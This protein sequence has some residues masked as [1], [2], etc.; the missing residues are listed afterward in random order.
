[1]STVRTTVVPHPA[2]GMCRLWLRQERKDATLR[3]ADQN[4]EPIDPH[5]LKRR[6]FTRG[7]CLD[8]P[9]NGFFPLLS[10]IRAWPS[11]AAS[12]QSCSVYLH[13]KPIRSCDRSSNDPASPHHPSAL[14]CHAT[15]PSLSLDCALQVGCPSHLERLDPTGG[16]GLRWFRVLGLE[17]DLFRRDLNLGGGVDGYGGRP[18]MRV[19]ER[20]NHRIPFCQPQHRLWRF[21]RQ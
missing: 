20:V 2:Q 3:L 17:V 19:L 21:D 18:G 9:H 10:P 1:M 8:A 12:P 6:A 7:R 15:S 5:R 4:H 16:L 13:A 14:S 11:C